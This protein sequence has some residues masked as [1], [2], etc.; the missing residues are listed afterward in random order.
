MLLGEDLHQMVGEVGLREQRCFKEK[1]IFKEPMPS[2]NVL[3]TRYSDTVS[4]TVYRKRTHT[5]SIFT[6][7]VITQFMKSGELLKRCIL[8]Q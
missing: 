1:A 5:G 2:L 8:T 6:L 4:T 3:Y 7:I